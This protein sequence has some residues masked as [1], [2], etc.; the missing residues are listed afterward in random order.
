MGSAARRRIVSSTSSRTTSK[1]SDG[2]IAYTV[3]YISTLVQGT[4]LG[5]GGKRTVIANTVV[6]LYR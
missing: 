4:G 5:R 2:M 3:P 1:D 6:I